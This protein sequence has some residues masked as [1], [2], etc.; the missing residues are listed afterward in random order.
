MKFSCVLF[1]VIAFVPCIF[2]SFFFNQKKTSSRN[3]HSFLFDFCSAYFCIKFLAN[4]SANSLQIFVRS[5][6]TSELRWQVFFSVMNSVSPNCHFRSN[7]IPSVLPKHA[8]RCHRFRNRK[9]SLPHILYFFWSSSTQWILSSTSITVLFTA[10]CWISRTKPIRRI[11]G[12]TFLEIDVKGG[13]RDHIKAYHQGERDHIKS[14]SP[15]K[16]KVLRGREY[17]RI[18]YIKGE[19]EISKGERILKDPRCLMFK[20]RDATCLFGGKTCSYELIWIKFY[21]YLSAL[22][23]CFLSSPNIPCKIQGEQDT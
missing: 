11:P 6:L 12:K 17:S 9:N 3:F 16:E 21:S 20:R 8:T 14:L 19:K 13:E 1:W 15:T 23:F 18:P 5:Y 10:L 4:L 22:I 2:V 7:R